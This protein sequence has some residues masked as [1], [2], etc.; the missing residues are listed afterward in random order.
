MDVLEQR[1]DNVQVCQ[2]KAGLL[3]LARVAPSSNSRPILNDTL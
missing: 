2:I 1:N 3:S